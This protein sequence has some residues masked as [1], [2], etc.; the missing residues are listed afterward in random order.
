MAKGGFWSDTF[1]QL[2]Q[3]GTSTAKQT[4]QAVKSVTVGSLQKAL[5]EF[6]GGASS[7]QSSD[8][9]IEK[10]E[11]GQAKKQNY[12]PLDPKKLEEGYKK[13]DQQKIMDVRQKLWHYFNLEKQEEKKATEDT[14]REEEERKRKEEWQKE[15][16]KKRIEEKAKQQPFVEAPKGRER[17]SIFA[18]KKV[19]KRSQ[20]ETRVGAGKQ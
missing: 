19:A 5:E 6:T 8:K 9:G 11:K 2:E 12:T 10:L 13:Q 18:P 7:P 15:E 14:K 16:E 1:E 4:G 20:M 3:L 17:R